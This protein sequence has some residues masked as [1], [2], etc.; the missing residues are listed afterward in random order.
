MNE[1][2]SWMTAVNR[3]VEGKQTRKIMRYNGGHPAFRAHCDAVAAD[4]LSQA[5]AGLDHTGSARTPFRAVS[6][7]YIAR[8]RRKAR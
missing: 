7:Q 1:I 2:V 6:G 5:G 4:G 8:R 3:N